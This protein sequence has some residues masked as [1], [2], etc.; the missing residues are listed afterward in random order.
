MLASPWLGKSSEVTRA[1]A[2]V[3]GSTSQPGPCPWCLM[4][5]FPPP[6]PCPPA[7]MGED[8]LLQFFLGALSHQG[9]VS[10]SDKARVEEAM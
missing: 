4:V 2:P 10:D 5:P 6:L 3:S 1:T 9:G 8:C 7:A